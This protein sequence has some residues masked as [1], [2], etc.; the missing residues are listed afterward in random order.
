MDICSNRDSQ[1]LLF[2]N[3]ACIH[4]YYRHVCIS[5]CSIS[6]INKIFMPMQYRYYNKLLNA[7][8]KIIIVVKQSSILFSLYCYNR[9]YCKLF[10]I[11]YL[12]TNIMLFHTLIKKKSVQNYTHTAII[13]TTCFSSWGKGH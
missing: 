11:H 13:G 6:T 9:N 2:C 12:K 4:G 8:R 5:M 7:N 3:E 1:Q 10:V